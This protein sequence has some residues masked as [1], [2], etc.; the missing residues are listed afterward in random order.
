MVIMDSIIFL[1]KLKSIKNFTNRN[2]NST[3]LFSDCGLL[4]IGKNMEK[5]TGYEKVFH[6]DQ[7]TTRECLLSEEIDLEFEKQQQSIQENKFKE[8]WQEQ[9]ENDFIM[10]DD[11]TRGSKRKHH[12]IM[13][14]LNSWILQLP[15]TSNIPT[16][17]SGHAPMYSIHRVDVVKSTKIMY[18]QKTGCTNKIKS[19]CS[20]ISSVCCVSIETSRKQ[21]GKTLS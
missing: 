13:K 19:G 2:L 7:Q 12:L 6:F 14:L 10:Q 21:S 9:S 4:E 17:K 15:N 11:E 5:L 1:W 18:K 16:N 8:K 3:Y 20:R